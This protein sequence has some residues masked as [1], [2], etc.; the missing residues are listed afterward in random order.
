MLILHYETNNILQIIILHCRQLLNSTI[1]IA[2]VNR[3]YEFYCICFKN[4]VVV[5]VHTVA[6]AVHDIHFY[7]GYV[8]DVAKLVTWRLLINCRTCEIITACL[9]QNNVCISLIYYHQPI[10][11]QDENVVAET[12]PRCS[13]TFDAQPSTDSVV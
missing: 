3:K 7:L 5:S 6:T 8:V 13:H 11:A 4:W 2:F 12:L 9:L 10:R 1:E